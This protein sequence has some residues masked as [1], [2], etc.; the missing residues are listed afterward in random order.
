MKT[1]LKRLLAKFIIWGIR[2]HFSEGITE[3]EGSN[4]RSWEV[5]GYR[6]AWTKEFEQ[7]L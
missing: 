1:K 7:G 6:W 3:V 2:N 4:H 5:I